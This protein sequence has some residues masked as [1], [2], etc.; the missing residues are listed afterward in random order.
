MVYFYL[1]LLAL[2]FAAL[3]FLVHAFYFSL[4]DHAGLSRESATA[5]KTPEGN[6]LEVERA[7][8]EVVRTSAPVCSPVDEFKAR[9]REM[10]SLESMVVRQDDEIRQLQRDSDALRT[11]L[12]GLETSTEPAGPPLDLTRANPAPDSFDLEARGAVRAAAGKRATPG[13]NGAEG[14]AWRDNLD[15]ILNT[16][17]SMGKEIDK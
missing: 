4:P 3:G 10:E 8:E 11:A 5:R 16:L 2:I 14:S 9:D 6:C 13:V 17:D 15:N 1:V 12:E 7:E